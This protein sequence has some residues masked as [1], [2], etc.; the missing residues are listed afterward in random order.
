VSYTVP[1][2]K[3]TPASR[4]GARFDNVKIARASEHASDLEDLAR[5]TGYSLTDG[6]AFRRRI[7]NMV[8]AGQIDPRFA[9]PAP[10]NLAR[11]DRSVRR[12]GNHSPVEVPR[13][14]VVIPT[15]DASFAAVLAAH[16]VSDAVVPG[17]GGVNVGLYL[18]TF[19]LGDQ[20]AFPPGMLPSFRRK[21]LV[22]VAGTALFAELA[23]VRLFTQAGWRAYWRD[24]YHRR[25]VRDGDLTREPTTRLPEPSVGASVAALISE[26][27]GSLSGCWDVLAWRQDQVAFVECKRRGRDRLQETQGLWLH[28]AVSVGIPSSA[29]AVLEWDLEPRAPLTRN[30]LPRIA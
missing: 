6:G 19:Q 24:G 22:D 18:R 30:E 27:R 29:F 4:P 8:C 12:P 10:Q 23:V 1:G 25:W 5:M 16:R 15:A 26:A 20:A 17:S 13:H 9:V 14:V 11:R 21:G 28:A 7:A 2:L 3:P